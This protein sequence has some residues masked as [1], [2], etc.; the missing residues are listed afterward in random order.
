MDER[1]AAPILIIWL[2]GWRGGSDDGILLSSICMS[3]EKALFSPI[4]TRCECGD[5]KGFGE[6]LDVNARV[7]LP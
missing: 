6:L 5:G 3:L 2:P 4:E 1:G 7:N